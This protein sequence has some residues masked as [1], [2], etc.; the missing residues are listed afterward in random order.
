MQK[1]DEPSGNDVTDDIAYAPQTNNGVD[2]YDAQQ[3][4]Q[5]VTPQQY[6]EVTQSKCL[7]LEYI[8]DS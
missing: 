4:I 5:Y 6:E 7:T 3:Q 2:E 1:S 8:I